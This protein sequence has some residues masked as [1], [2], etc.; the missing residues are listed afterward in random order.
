MPKPSTTRTPA[1]TCSGVNG[2]L[3]VL[4]HRTNSYGN[5]RLTIYPPGANGNILPVAV[6]EGP[7]TGLVMSNS[8]ALDAS[9]NIYVTNLYNYITFYPAG[10]K[11]NA[12]P[13]RTIEG[14]LTRMYLPTQVAL[15][16]SLNIYVANFNDNSVTV[17]AAGA[18]GNVGPIQD[19][20][21]HRAGIAGTEGTAVDANGNIY[22]ANIFNRGRRSFKAALRSTRRAQMVTFVRSKQSWGIARVSFGP[23]VCQFINARPSF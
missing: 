1:R 13:T 3:Y 18:N 23:R 11:G 7:S 2:D 8:L 9:G 21:G 16:S 15:D 14:G 4:N 20:H 10:S 5:G 22:V 19:I 17:Y 12:T 6:I